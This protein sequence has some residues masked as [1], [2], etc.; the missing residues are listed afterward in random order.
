MY[1]DNERAIT[2]IVQWSKSA[3]FNPKDTKQVNVVGNSSSAF[4]STLLKLDTPMEEFQVFVRVA[5][6]TLTSPTWS[7]ISLGWTTT[8]TCGPYQYLDDM[9]PPLDK[10]NQSLE[11][12]PAFEYL[13]LVLRV[14]NQP[15][16]RLVSVAP[17]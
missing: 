6:Y 15:K 4:Q 14:E 11:V 1:Q 5:T 8:D 10:A 3:E 7:P 17:D 2:Y 13:I 12:N 16:Q 9:W